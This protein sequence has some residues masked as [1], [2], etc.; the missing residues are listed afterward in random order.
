MAKGRTLSHITGKPFEDQVRGN[1]DR[2]I[3]S[4]RVTAGA[5]STNTRRITIQVIDRV[6]VP[7]KARFCVEVWLQATAGGDPSATGNTVSWVAPIP[8]ATFLPNG[9]WRVITDSDGQA[10]FDVE[11]TGAATRYVGWCMGSEVQVSQA[12]TW[13]A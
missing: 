3:A 7:W 11:I 10:Q 9:H 5:E 8:Y 12:F 2:D 13:S 4:L 6:N 1:F